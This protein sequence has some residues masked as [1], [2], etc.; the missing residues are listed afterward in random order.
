MKY[1]EIERKLKKEGCYCVDESG[2]HPEWYV[3][4]NR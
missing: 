2:K 4:P 3:L 1:S